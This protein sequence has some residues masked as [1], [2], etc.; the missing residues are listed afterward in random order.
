MPELSLANVVSWAVQVTAIG[1]AGVLLPLLLRVTSPRAR[2]FY[3]RALLVA[4]L[5]L[6]LL[7]PWVPVPAPGSAPV[8]AASVSIEDQALL[9][10]SPGG[11]VPAASTPGPSVLASIRRWPVETTV[12]GIYVAGVAMRLAWLGIGLLSLARLRRSSVPLAPRPAAIDDAALLTGVDADFHVSSRVV[13]PVTFGLRRPVVLVPPSFLSFEA[14]QQ[15]AVAVH[16]LLHVARR[17]WVRTLGD[18]LILSVFWFHPALWWLVDQIHLSVEQVVD[19]AV[20]RLAGA[21]KPYLEALLKLAA[22][23]P[24]PMLQPASAFLKHGHLAQRVALL[25]R[26]A[27]MSRLRLVA[28]FAVALAVLLAGGTYVVQAFPLTVVAEPVAAVLPPSPAPVAH[29]PAAPP[30]PPPAPPKATVDQAAGQQAKP[31][32]PAGARAQA[33]GAPPASPVL[34]EAAIRQHIA[35]NQAD[36]TWYFVLAKFFEDKSDLAKAERALLDAKASQPTDVKVLLQLAGY[37]NR[38]GDFQKTIGA[39]EQRFAIDAGNPEAPYTLAT[40]YWDKAYR[41]QALSA[42]DKGELVARGLEYADDAIRLKADYM[43]ALTYKNLLLRLKATNESDPSRQQAL[44]AQADALRDQAI[45]IKQAREVWDAVPPNAVRVGGN[46]AP[47]KKLK[48]VKP[49]YPELATSARVQGVVIVEAVI[50]QDGKVQNSRVLRSIPLL[51]Q[52]AL[53]AVKQWEFTPTILN[54]EYVPVVMTVTVNFTLGDGTVAYVAAP[55]P[56]PPPPPAPAKSAG[57]PGGVQGGVAGGVVGGVAGGVP[58]GVSSAADNSWAKSIDPNAIRVGGDIR[59]PAKIA[60]ARPIYP[61]D[62]QAAGVQGI[63]ILEAVIAPDGHVA[64]ARVLRSVP[65]LDDAAYSAVMKWY[66]TPTIVNGQAV[67]VIMTV[68]V[69]FTLQ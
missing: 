58:G 2:L 5:A 12:L 56:P 61:A 20:V 66:F 29:A 28:S 31:T 48:D 37:Y 55:P 15:T 69:N 32:V 16:E 9:A 49:V 63:V 17:D 27:S 60:D 19:H 39:L 1:L 21:R 41:D 10:G 24:T 59:P 13:R 22:A 68:T 8:N 6:P 25:V 54:G 64:G 3:L 62:A 33:P 65:M 14:P 7:Q 34:D 44:I 36:V 35:A 47:P 26:E 52:G 23:G 11:G 42:A 4:C 51:D 18:E 53:D 50:G 43:E 57:V 46:I 30:P 67:P 45:K 38:R 40:Y